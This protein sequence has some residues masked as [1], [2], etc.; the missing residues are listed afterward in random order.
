MSEVL[1]SFKVAMKRGVIHSFIHLFTH[2]PFTERLLCAR[3]YAE[4]LELSNVVLKGAH[5]TVWTG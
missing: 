5:G 1:K 2:P 4:D 3:H